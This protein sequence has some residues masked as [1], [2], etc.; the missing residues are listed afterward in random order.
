MSMDPDQPTRPIP[1]T[2]PPREPIIEREVPVAD[3][4]LDDAVRS[5]RTWLALATLVALAALGLAL[6]AVLTKEE[7]EDAQ[8][9]A[10]VEQVERLEQRVEDLES[11]LDQRATKGELQE[12]AEAQVEIREQIEGVRRQ[13]RDR[14]DT[15]ALQE[16]IDELQQSVDDV[17]GD[18]QEL[19]QRVADV[20]QR[21]D[22]QE[23]AASP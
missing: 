9:G 2:G 3:P 19:D 4:V 1:P 7:E 6:W 22:E 13:A 14:G 11:R 12:V 20:E 16:S 18:V 10:T 17:A 15:E 23:A 8:R 5:L 21:Q